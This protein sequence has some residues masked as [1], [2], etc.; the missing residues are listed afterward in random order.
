MPNEGVWYCSELETTIVF[1]KVNGIVQP[2]YVVIDDEE[3]NCICEGEYNTPYLFLCCQ[4]TG[5]SEFNLGEIIYWWTLMAYSENEIILEDYETKELY[6]F[7]RV[8]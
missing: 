7:E 6:Y 5:I 8:A 2:S 4:E 1:D 3:I